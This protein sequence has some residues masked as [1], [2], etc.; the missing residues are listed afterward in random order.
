MCDFLSPRGLAIV[1]VYFVHRYGGSWF[2]SSFFTACPRVVT[3]TTL[4]AAGVISSVFTATGRAFH[5]VRAALQAA[6]KRCILVISSYEL[7]G[8]G[9]RETPDV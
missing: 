5:T 1:V 8:S 7:V 6:T 4:Q 2:A 9:N 3:P